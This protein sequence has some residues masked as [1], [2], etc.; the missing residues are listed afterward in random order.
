MCSYFPDLISTF[1]VFIYLFKQKHGTFQCVM[2]VLYQTYIQIALWYTVQSL[3]AAPAGGDAFI[4]TEVTQSGTVWQEGLTKATKP[5]WIRTR[6]LYIKEHEISV[7]WRH[8]G[9]ASC[10]RTSVGITADLSVCLSVSN[11]AKLLIN[12]ASHVHFSLQ[13][14]SSGLCYWKGSVCVTERARSEDLRP[15]AVW[16]HQ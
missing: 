14:V 10:W 16:F 5:L 1:H 3:L 12:T 6:N 15:E 13:R 7:A 8:S 2:C 9:H 11:L 4:R